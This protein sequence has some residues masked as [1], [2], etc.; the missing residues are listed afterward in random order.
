MRDRRFIP[1]NW[2]R[3][4]VRAFSLAYDSWST[5]D[6]FPP[7]KG[8]RPARADKKTYYISLGRQHRDWSKAVLHRDGMR[9]QRCGQEEELEAHHIWPQGWFHH[10]RYLL[11]NG[12][13]L[14]R[15]CHYTADSQSALTPNQFQWLTADS[16]LINANIERDDFWEHFTAGEQKGWLKLFGIDTQEI[17]WESPKVLE[18]LDWFKMVATCRNYVDRIRETAGTGPCPDPGVTLS[19]RFIQEIERL[20][21]RD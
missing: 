2:E 14:C 12:V 16:G 8:Y 10:L 11:R 20:Q 13:T 7:P 21:E 1:L 9:C 4:W 17:D 15:E 5:F 3:H 18:E 19:S 6:V